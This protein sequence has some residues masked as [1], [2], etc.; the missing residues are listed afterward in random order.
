MSTRYA[1]ELAKAGL[2]EPDPE[3][4]K[5]RYADWLPGE[6]ARIEAA[7]LAEVLASYLSY[8]ALHVQ[9]SRF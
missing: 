5:L 7:R 9:S 3:R 4:G 8:G 2:P 6:L 1:K